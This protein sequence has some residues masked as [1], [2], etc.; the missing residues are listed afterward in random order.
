MDTE[1]KE[2]V[3]I[4]KDDGIET[5]IMSETDELSELS[6]IEEN[7]KPSKKKEEEEDED[8]LTRVKKE[9][10]K[11]KAEED[12]DELTRVKKAED[13]KTKAAA[14][15]KANEAADKKAKEL[16]EVARNTLLA[17]I[18]NQDDDTKLKEWE[19]KNKLAITND[20]T[21]ALQTA[22][23][24]QR[25]LN[26]LLAEIPN[27][28]DDTK[29]KAWE[30]KNKL[31]ITN[32]KTKALQ[33][34]VDAQRAL[35]TTADKKAEAAEAAEDK[36]KKT[37]HAREK[38]KK[39]VSE[40]NEFIHRMMMMLRYKYEYYEFW[41]LLIN[42][43][44]I[45]CSSVITFLESLR[46]NITQDD[47]LDFWFTIITLSLGFIIAFS[48]SVFKFLKIQDKMEIIQSGILGLQAPYKEISQFYNEVETHW[49]LENIKK[50]EEEDKNKDEDEDKNKN[51]NKNATI[52]IDEDF[53]ND[54]DVEKKWKKLI[55]KSVHPVT[56]ADTIISSGEYYIYE[57][58]YKESRQK[59][60][61]MQD[62]IDLETLANKNLKEAREVILG[63]MV[64]PTSELYNKFGPIETMKMANNIKLDYWGEGVIMSNNMQR[65]HDKIL[66]I[67][68]QDKCFNS[69]I[70]LYC[71][72]CNS[73]CK[74]FYKSIGY[75]FICCRPRCCWNNK[76]KRKHEWEREEEEIV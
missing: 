36:I 42:V 41:N 48:L 37:E 66:G 76:D 22:V 2:E 7:S 53:R 15:R 62:K 34:A 3:K 46:A 10:E 28:D 4:N 75:C 6:E 56:L 19:G 21:K 24:A 38:L 72:F 40:R 73:W 49:K 44:I 52:E 47:D 8:E 14:D 18:P 57:K 64:R 27:Q 74:K 5:L 12:E 50:E 58:K 71:C 70:D 20:K 35:N 67:K 59:I 26:T 68:S 55:I 9:L 13:K 1:K 54:K 65:K 63:D 33:T 45:L 30:G 29:L 69:C 23:D 32:D 17:E 43:V 25:A 39:H 51:K 11:L 31:A 61:K 60:K 16:K